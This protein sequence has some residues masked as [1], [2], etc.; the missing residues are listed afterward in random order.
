P[1]HTMDTLVQDLD[2]LMR[3]AAPLAAPPGDARFGLCRKGFDGALYVEAMP[4]FSITELR[5]DGDLLKPVE[6]TRPGEGSDVGTDPG[7]DLRPTRA[8]RTYYLAYDK[9]GKG[10]KDDWM[11]VE[12]V[13]PPTDG[14]GAPRTIDNWPNGQF[15]VAAR[16]EAS[17]TDN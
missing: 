15:L 17:R 7:L 3:P 2:A 4:A 16:T 8:L 9:R 14:A 1:A 12:W 6:P 13:R 5:V 11:V 10:E